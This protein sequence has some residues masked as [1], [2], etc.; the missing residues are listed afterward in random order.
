MKLRLAM[1]IESVDN[2][3]LLRSCA[4]S[5]VSVYG[6]LAGP[7]AIATCELRQARKGA[8]V[9]VSYVPG[10]GWL[11]CLHIHSS[12]YS[13]LA[14]PPIPIQYQFLHAASLL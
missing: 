9:A 1:R 2:A 6:D 14:S 7:L 8:T 12:F 10:C 5:A 11:D 13:S 3:R 4:F